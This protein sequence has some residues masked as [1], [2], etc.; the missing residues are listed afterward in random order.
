MAATIPSCEP[1]T[2]VAGDTVQWTKALAKYPPSEGWSLSYSLKL[3]SG[4]VTATVTD[5]GSIFTATIAAAYTAAIVSQTVVRLMGYVTGSGT[6]VGQRYSIF[7]RYITVDP[8]PATA[9]AADLVTENET[10]L[11]AAQAQLDQLLSTSIESYSVGTRS[12]TK[13][14]IGELRAEIGRLQLTVW[15]EQNRGQA[16]PQYANVFVNA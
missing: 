9:T 1:V 10:R 12:A 3:A 2:F 13:R 14:K 5:D 16:F 6:Y 11:I 8:N 7:D 15:R 4:V